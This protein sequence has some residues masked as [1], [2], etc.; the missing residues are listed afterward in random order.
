MPTITHTIKTKGEN[1]C[2][3]QRVTWLGDNRWNVHSYTNNTYLVRVGDYTEATADCNCEW[4]RHQGRTCSHIYAVLLAY[5][6][7]NYK[8][9]AKRWSNPVDPFEGIT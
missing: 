5:Q 4:N 2:N 7:D 8:T 6:T 9:Q 3:D 1:L